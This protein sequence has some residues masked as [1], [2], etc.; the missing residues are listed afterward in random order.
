L[1]RKARYALLCSIFAVVSF[2]VVGPSSLRSL[3]RLRCCLVNEAKASVKSCFMS[4][5]ISWLRC[6]QIGAV[7]A[8]TS[9]NWLRT[10][11]AA[12]PN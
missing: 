1:S 12:A 10:E 6:K 7:R 3:L 9:P 4:A 8:L 2:S 5:E 11:T